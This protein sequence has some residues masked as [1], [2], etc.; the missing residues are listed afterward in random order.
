MNTG[1]ERKT[2]DKSG[3]GTTGDPMGRVPRGGVEVP[4]C[5]G[6]EIRRHI[7]ALQLSLPGGGFIREK[8]ETQCLLAPTIPGLG[9]G[10]R[11]VDGVTY[12]PRTRR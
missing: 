3:E 4:G 9:G 11:K 7:P 12:N 1:Q 2:E 6:Q 8:V 5:V 10:V